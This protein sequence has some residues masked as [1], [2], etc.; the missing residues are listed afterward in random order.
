MKKL[1]FLFWGIS[2]FALSGCI[3]PGSNSQKF[4]EVPAIVGFSIEALQ[5]TINI[6]D[7]GAGYL[8]LLA[9]TLM[10][11]ELDDGDAIIANFTINYD[12][13][14]TQYYTVSDLTWD[15]V[16]QDYP[17]PKSE[18]DDGFDEPIEEILQWGRISYGWYDIL[19][20]K[21]KQTAPSDQVFI[22]EMT[23]GLDETGLSTVYISAQ[24]SGE[25]SNPSEVNSFYYAFNIK[26]YL[27]TLSV[28][29]EN[30]VKFYIEFKTGVDSEGRDVYKSWSG[31]PLRLLMS[32][33]Y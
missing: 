19:F 25:G 14:S 5:T 4:T 16:G 22:Y 13:Q 24:K 32:N 21:F 18:A 30:M 20:F 17:K 28:D 7:G 6:S 9:P 2:T 23:Y 12:Q 27:S 29:Y 33:E 3:K 10:S 31:N 15:K 11:A 8:P 26:D 1:I